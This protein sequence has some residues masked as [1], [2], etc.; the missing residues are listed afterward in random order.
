M[1]ANTR[2]SL[3]NV[4]ITTFNAC[5]DATKKLFRE[6]ALSLK[7]ELDGGE[8]GADESGEPL[9]NSAYLWVL[10]HNSTTP[11]TADGVYQTFIFLDKNTGEFLATGSTTTDREQPRRPVR[12]ERSVQFQGLCTATPVGS[13]SATLRVTTVMP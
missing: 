8:C 12:S 1:D 3:K 7:P 6:W 2:Y 13:K 11:F 10:H 4:S 9:P 5:D